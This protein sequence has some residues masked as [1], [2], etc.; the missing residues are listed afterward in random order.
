MILTNIEITSPQFCEFNYE[1][2]RKL[3]ELKC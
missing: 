1:V 3:S 2:A